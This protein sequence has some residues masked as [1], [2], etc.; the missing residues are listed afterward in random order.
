M[1]EKNC[2]IIIKRDNKHHVEKKLCYIT[3][4]KLGSG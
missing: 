4:S 1:K 2:R 3:E